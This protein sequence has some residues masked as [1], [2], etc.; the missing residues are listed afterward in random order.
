MRKITWHLRGYDEAPAPRAGHLTWSYEQ[1]W[2]LA[3]VP[4]CAHGDLS[5]WRQSQFKWFLRDEGGDETC[6]MCAANAFVDGTAELV[7]VAGFAAYVATCEAKG[8]RH[9][10]WAG[11]HPEIAAEIVTAATSRRGEAAYA[12]L[13]IALEAATATPERIEE[14]AALFE[15]ILDG[16]RSS[17]RGAA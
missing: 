4:C 10:D 17:R 16:R 14:V 13:L 15:R 3:G 6:E 5:G 2:R 7:D 8:R 9:P 1:T 11:E 12:N